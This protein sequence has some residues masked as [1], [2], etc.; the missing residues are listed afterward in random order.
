V[1]DEN[2]RELAGKKRADLE[3]EKKPRRRLIAALRE[4]LGRLKL[5]PAKKGTQNCKSRVDLELK[6]E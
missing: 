4:E 3:T 6:L 1:L 5:A 2:G